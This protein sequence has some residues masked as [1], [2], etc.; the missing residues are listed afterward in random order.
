[1]SRKILALALVVI[2]GLSL[3]GCMEESGYYVPEPFRR[4]RRLGWRG[5]RR[6]PGRHYRRGHRLSRYRRLDRRRRPALWWAAWAVIS[7]PSIAMKNE[8]H[9][10][11]GWRLL[12]LICKAV[13]LL[14]AT[15]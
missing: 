3:V 15:W 4:R 10:A 8:I 7:M 12:I 9:E 5:H 13:S 6:G 14:R 1:M 2:F 11:A